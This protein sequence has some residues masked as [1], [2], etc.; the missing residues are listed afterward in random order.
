MKICCIS[1]THNKIKFLTLPEADLLIISGDLTSSGSVNQFRQFNKDIENLKG[2]YTYGILACPGN[3]D[4]LAE[5]NF[6]WARGTLSNVDYFLH[7]QTVTINNLKIFASA[8]TP[9]FFDWAF[10]EERGAAIAAKWAKIELNTDIVVTHG[11][12][13]GILDETP[14]GERVGCQDLL[15]KVL[16]VKPKLHVFGH[17]H[18][19]YGQQDFN[20]THFVNAASCNERYEPIHPPILIDWAEEIG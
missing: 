15:D 6:E 1:D 20:G 14:S 4:F 18:H 10:N 19:S 2:R 13:M 12:P 3:H 16:E 17:I 8:C 11:P 9:A 7:Q 5:E